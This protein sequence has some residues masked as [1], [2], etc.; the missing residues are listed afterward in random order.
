MRAKLQAIRKALLKRR[1]RPIPE[2]GE[3]LGSV[4]RGH[5]AYFAVPTNA[6]RLCSFR[7]EVRRSWLRALRRRSQHDRIP[8]TRMHKLAERWLPHP[9]LQHPWP[10]KRFNARNQGRSRVR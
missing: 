4:V 9:R 3:W 7:Y 5:F 10:D 6:R 1:H 8:W 2:Q